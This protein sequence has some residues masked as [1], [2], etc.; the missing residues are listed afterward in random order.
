[1]ILWDVQGSQKSS[2]VIHY[3]RDNQA[4]FQINISTFFHE[5]IDWMMDNKDIQILLIINREDLITDEKLSST[6]IVGGT[7]FS[8][9]GIKEISVNAIRICA[10]YK[11]SSFGP[12]LI[13][14]ISSNLFLLYCH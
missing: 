7:L 4:F 12:L 9:H 5:H 3:Q 2:R 11:Y 14:F 10:S 1:M 8:I 6:S 13:H